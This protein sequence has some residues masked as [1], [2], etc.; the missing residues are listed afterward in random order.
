[1]EPL[2]MKK[3][4]ISSLKILLEDRYV[5]GLL[6]TFFVGCL[7][8]LGFLAVSIQPSELQVV[9]HYTSFGNTNF[10]RDRWFYLLSLGLFIVIMATIHT[11]L[12]YK[13]LQTKG[14]D[15]TIAFLWLSIIMLVIASALFYQVLKIA[16][17]S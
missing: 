6:A 15:F 3:Q 4:A 2:F 17:L 8:L 14:R 9:V 11:I 5:A 12:T 1:M 10:Y 7:I 13:I 16:S